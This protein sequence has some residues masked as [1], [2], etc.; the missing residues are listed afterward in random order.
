MKKLFLPISIL[1]T[2]LIIA[3]IQIYQA[4]TPKN[5]S[6]FIWSEIIHVGIIV[7]LFVLGL[8]FAVKRIKSREKGLPEDDELSL[9]ITQKA[10]AISFYISLFLWLVL[11]YIQNNTTIEST[12]LFG[13]GFIG[14][15]LA[16]ILSWFVFNSKGIRND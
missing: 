15:A 6:I 9:L 4:A 2:V 16:F 10:A 12:L 8:Y 3:G 14:M 11:L 7:L 1:T 5:T 13:Y